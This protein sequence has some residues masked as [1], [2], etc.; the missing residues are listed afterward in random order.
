MKKV[1]FRSFVVVFLL[2]GFFHSKASAATNTATQ[3]SVI[4]INVP[5]FKENPNLV[6][7]E[8]LVDLSFN[9]KVT[10]LE[11]VRNAAKIELEDGKVG[12]VYK[13][14]LSNDLSNQTWIVKKWR[15]LKDAPGF[16]SNVIGQIDDH[17]KVTVL[18]Y[19]ATTHY[20]KVQTMIDGKLQQGW[21]YGWYMD[22]NDQPRTT[23]GGSNVIP[24]E[25][26]KEGKVTNS[27]SLFTPLDTFSNITA[28]EINRFID[29]KTQE[30]S[31]KMKGMGAAYIEAQN[32][33]GL[34]AIYL[35]AHSGLE[36]KWGNSDIVGT[37]NNFYGIGAVDFDPMANAHKFDTP[38]KGIING[39]NYIKNHYVS[40]DKT[41][42]DPT[43]PFY[44]QP[45]LDNM[46]FNSGY[47]Q[48]ATD[49]A[50]AGKIAN[51]AKEFY[52]FT[53]ANG[54][55]VKK[56]WYKEGQNSYYFDQNGKMLTGKQSLDGKFYFF[57]DNGYLKT[58]W[59]NV[60]GKW[61]YVY[62]NVNG[63]G[64]Y[65]TGWF[66]DKDKKW[67]Y[68]NTQSGAML[69]GWQYINGKW[70]YLNASGDM[71]TG[72][73]FSGGKWYFLDQKNGDMKTGWLYTGGKW[74]YLNNSGAM[75]TGWIKLGGKWY[76][77]YKDGHMAANTTVGGYRLGKDG[78]ML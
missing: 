1:L 78:A 4:S 8:Q 66:L 68:L 16:S 51:I 61:F 28:N 69:T 67:Y 52:E 75:Q 42:E 27:I 19:D 62:V 9:A 74:Y 70:Y 18:G 30:P 36:S 6:K 54:E 3:M 21:I 10:V 57:N 23:D 71:K 37:K 55:K 40:W 5:F 7:S 58:G 17:S 25:F 15:N 63:N 59:Q 33:T 46:R 2:L 20:Y 31:S 45:T 64:T 35:L 32:V 26:E 72:W 14:Y 50:W 38:S 56:S 48:Y 11:E 77:L 76:Y 65:K 43:Y 53:F 39:A 13:E 44:S 60:G 34:N 22:I 29:Y 24:Y 73:L 49:P 47:H 12:W 41:V